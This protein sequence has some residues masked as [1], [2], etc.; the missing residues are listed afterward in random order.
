MSVSTEQKQL[1]KYSLSQINDFLAEAYAEKT[2]LE[3]QKK[4]KGKNWTEAEQEKLTEVVMAI[5][6]LE[7][8]A[9]SKKAFAKSNYEVKPGTEDLI[10]LRIVKGLRFNP[11]TGKAESKP[12]V[13]LFTHSEWRVFKEHF[14]GLGYLILGVMH[15]P[16]NEAEPYVFKEDE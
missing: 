1:D 10:H 16:Y 5:S 13:Q 2:A 6:D 4:A 3:A 14:K 8:T 12:Y 7:E 9:E 11:K 15:D